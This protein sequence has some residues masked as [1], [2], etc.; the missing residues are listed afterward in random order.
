VSRL[1]DRFDLWVRQARQSSDPA[2]A[3]DLVLG[4]LAALKEWHFLNIG[5]TD[6]PHAAETEVEAIPCLLVFTTADR[7]EEIIHDEGNPGAQRASL[8]TIPTAEAMAWCVERKAGLLVNPGD[9]SVLISADQLAVYHTEWQQRRGRQSTG[10]WI[11][12]PTNEE[13]DFWRE[14]GL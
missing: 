6:A 2:R 11:P 5:A 12:N 3:A 4:G 8:L 1:P 14:H 13:E 7:V 10:F 9:D